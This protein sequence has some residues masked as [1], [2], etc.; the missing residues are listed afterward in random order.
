MAAYFITYI[1]RVLLSVAA[2]F[3]QKEFHLDTITLGKVLMCYSIAYALFQIP[4][5]WFGDKVGPRL[6]MTCVVIWWSALTALTALSTSAVTMGI[7]LFLIGMGEAGAFPIANRA[8]SRWMLPSER[9]IAQG[10]T[11]AGSRL[12]STLT[13]LMVVPLVG[14]TALSWRLPFLVFAVVGVVW[15]LGWYAYYRNS[16]AEH[17]SVN[18]GELERI[19]GALG[20]F[21]KGKRKVPWR[22][23]LSNRQMW[24]LGAMYFCY[25]YDIGVFLSWFPKY[26]TAARGIELKNMGFYASVPFLAGLLGDVAG[27]ALSDHLLKTTGRHAWSRRVVSVSGFW[28]SAVAVSLAA[29]AQD[30]VVSIGWF[31]LGL[32]A[33]ELTVGVS[34]AVTLDVG[35]EFAGS[36]SAVMNTM[37]NIGAAIAVGVTAWFATQY[38]WASAFGIVAFLGAMAGLLM[39]RVDPTRRF[40]VD[41]PED[42]VTV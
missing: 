40:Y 13:P 16:P 4:G 29:L 5:G 2:P 31:S 39:L 32:F 1:D 14:L 37:G 9:A 8:L 18:E 3:I 33:L 17:A 19:T 28:A 42:G 25:A 23:I 34:W 12:G 27:G 10:A 24:I 26:L 11:H 20:P 38:G 21:A 22:Q 7:C 15:A 6:A 41:T 35:G 36:V 30:P